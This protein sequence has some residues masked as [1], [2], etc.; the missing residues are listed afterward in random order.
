[1][2]KN[3]DTERLDLLDPAEADQGGVGYE[4]HLIES[5]GGHD[6]AEA[7]PAPKRQEAEAKGKQKKGKQKSPNRKTSKAMMKRRMRATSATKSACFSM[8]RKTLQNLN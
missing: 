5:L 7:N 1:M 4:S 8:P 2:S 3:K 6:Q